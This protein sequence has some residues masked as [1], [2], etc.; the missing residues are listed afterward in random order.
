MEKEQVGRSLNPKRFYEGDRY[1]CNFFALGMNFFSYNFLFFVQFIILQTF[2][3]WISKPLCPVLGMD[4][5]MRKM[6]SPLGILQPTRG[7]RFLIETKRIFSIVF[8]FLEQKKFSPC[9]GCQE[10]WRTGPSRSACANAIWVP[11]HLRDHLMEQPQALGTRFEW[12]CSLHK[13]EQKCTL[14][15]KQ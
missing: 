15:S 1:K 9:L 10:L 14:P 12:L 3:E 13:R 7:N 11:W 8:P 2:S 6:V 5:K 4:M